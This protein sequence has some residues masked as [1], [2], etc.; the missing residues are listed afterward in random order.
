MVSPN[1]MRRLLDAAAGLTRLVTLAP[2]R[3]EGL[4]VTRMLADQGIAVAAGVF[5]QQHRAT[6]A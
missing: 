1:V 4:R 2:E 5:L 6:T 3:D